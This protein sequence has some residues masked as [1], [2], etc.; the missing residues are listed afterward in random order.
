M[1]SICWNLKRSGERFFHGFHWECSADSPVQHQGASLRKGSNISLNSSYL[2]PYHPEKTNIKPE[3]V[4]VWKGTSFCLHTLTNIFSFQGVCALFLLSYFVLII[5]QDVFAMVFVWGWSLLLSIT[6]H[7]HPKKNTFKKRI[8]PTWYLVFPKCEELNTSVHHCRDLGKNTTQIIDYYGIY[9]YTQIKV[10]I[11][12]SYIC[13]LIFTHLFTFYMHPHMIRCIYE[14]MWVKKWVDD[15]WSAVL[16]LYSKILNTI[17]W[18]NLITFPQAPNSCL[19]AIWKPAFVV[20]RD[21]TTL[22]PDITTDLERCHINEQ[23]GRCVR[24][25]W[26]QGI[27][28]TIAHTRSGGA[29]EPKLEKDLW[30]RGIPW[31]ESGTSLAFTW[32]SSRFPWVSAEGVMKYL[33]TN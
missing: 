19:E 28:V 17:H 23:N 22:H 26:V 8:H 7:P 13:L 1:D 33:F 11:Y 27:E 29:P 20:T 14:T 6:Y 16:T 21:A 18:V 32:S 2:H 30:L 25:G 10:F 24:K 3:K 31:S 12:I 9:W 4:W 15:F 5:E